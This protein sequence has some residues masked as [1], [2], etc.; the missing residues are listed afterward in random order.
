MAN[1]VIITKGRDAIKSA[2][3]RLNLAVVLKDK[4]EI[5][6]KPNLRAAAVK[7][8]KRCAITNPDVTRAVVEK[9]LDLGKRVTVAECTSSKSITEKAIEM[10]G[11]NKLKEIGANVV[12]LNLEKTKNVYT[13]P[14]L[15]NIDIPEVV[16]D[17][18]YLIS[19]PVMKTHSMTLVSLSMKNMIGTVGGVQPPKM[20]YVGI[21]RA[22]VDLLNVV[23][24]NLSIIDA[25][26]AMEGTGPVYGREVRLN[27]IIAGFD[28]VAVDA[29][30]AK[31]MGFNPLEVDHIRLASE[32]KLGSIHPD[33]IVGKIEVRKFKRPDRERVGEFINSKMFNYLISNRIVHSL[34]YDYSYFFI[35][36]LLDK[37]KGE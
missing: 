32:R 4:E 5:L 12:N 7:G 23:R 17:A 9:I 29:V 10:S 24:P 31:I 11:T 18:N 1:E 28:P 30:G 36:P 2:L 21:S 34:V 27:T 22:I 15:K 35:R 20:H 13:G 16:L 6:V 33:K 8:Y 25:T 19:L 14:N 37:I 26:R 3:K